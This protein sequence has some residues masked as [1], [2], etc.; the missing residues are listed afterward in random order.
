M[1]YLGDY[2]EDETVYFLW[3][4]N[5]SS[6]AS[7][8][9]ATD[10]TV[11]VYKDNGTTQSTAGVTDTED[12]DSLTGVHACTIDLSSNVFY[13]IGADYSV[14]L[15]ASTIDG[16]TV[17]TPLAHFSIENRTSFPKADFPTNFSSLGIESDGDL[18]KVNTLDGH[19]A[20]TADHTA[21]IADIP[22]VSEFNAR[23]LLAA[24]YFDPTTD[25]VANVTTTA[26][27]T[28]NNDKTGY[29]ISGTLTTLDALDTAQDTQHSQTQSDIAAL[30]DIAATDIV[31][32]GAITTLAGA[33]VNVDTVDTTTTNSDMR[34]TDNAALASALSTHDGKLDTVDTNVDAILVDT[35]TTIP[36]QISAL[37]DFD[38]ATD[39]VDLGSI[40]GTALTETNA[41]DLANNVSQF[42]DVNPTTT[43]T[44]DDVGVAGSGLTQQNVRDAMKLAPTAGAPAAGSVD[45]HLDDILADT[46]ELQSDDVPGLIAALNDFDPTTDTVANVTL[47]ATTT[48]NT[49]MRGTDNAAT[50]AALTTHD[51]KLDTVDTNVD[52]ILVDTGTTLPA[53]LTD[54]QGA[55]FNTS[56]D[57]LEAIRNR[58]DAAWTTG[59]GTG[60]SSLAS[61]TAQAGAAGSITLAAGETS[62]NDLYNNTKILLTGGTGS[63]QSRIITDYNGTTKVATVAPNWV[64]NP[65]NTSTYEIQAADSYLDGYTSTRAGYLDELSSTNMPA[66]L[67]AVL[68]DTNELQGDWVDGG[69]LDLI[70]DS[71]STQTSVNTIDTNVDAILVDTAE[72]GVAGAGLTD[73]G[74]MST[75]MKAEVN[76]EVDTALSDYDAPTNTEMTAAFTEIKGTTWSSLTDTLEAIRDVEPHGTVMRGT[77]NA[78]TSAELSTHDG[79]LDTVDTNVD[80]VLTDTNELQTDW[81]NG[82]RLDLI[83]DARS[84]Q[85]SVDTIDTNVDAIL[86]DTGT[87]IPAQI[88]AL[89]DLSAAEVNAEIVDVLTV[90]TIADSYA[91]DG[92]QPTIAQAILA[93]QQF[94]TEKSV[95]GTT[96]TVKKPDGTTTAMTFTLDSGTTPS[97]IT[98]AS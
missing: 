53:T 38:P 91:T 94:L 92:S 6:G 48:T 64:T 8:T 26:N 47:V 2:A 72:I 49:D 43:K 5:D 65:D 83:L 11:S 87:T 55:T 95:T 61:G 76:T 73:L 44:V 50:A 81:T 58:G 24:N 78:A 60:L 19:T 25:T 77:D 37:N 23:T 29:S 68:A 97:S 89:N 62:T 45:E 67:D 74:G 75:G 93:I 71:R 41:G 9:R 28:T 42:Y 70:L 13:A 96:V 7:I 63:G 14:V 90:D 32:N 54:I 27:L 1:M 52:A 85:S 15:S 12:F 80:S 82:G 40:K 46:N 16:Q 88:S 39:E 10:G 31:S 86:V 66:D 18:T 30:N 57:S 34:G 69:R 51:G 84:S 35:G 21:G 4:T 33:V 36:A 22:T 17:N 3:S 56:T 79:K 98:R 59:S 20:Q